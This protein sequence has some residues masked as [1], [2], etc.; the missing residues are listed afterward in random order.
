MYNNNKSNSIYS[1]NEKVE[2]LLSKRGVCYN[3]HKKEKTII[4]K[5][6]KKLS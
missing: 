4:S 6:L 2:K 1:A 5:K 3:S